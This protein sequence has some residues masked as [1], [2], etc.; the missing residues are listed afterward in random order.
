MNRR[1]LRAAAMLVLLAAATAASAQ[2]APFPTRPIK[3]VVPYPPGGPLDTAARAPAEQVKQGLGVVVVE[4]RPG[5]G[6]NIGVDQV[7][8]SVPDGYTLVIGAVATHAVNPWLFRKL[9]YDPV[10]DFVPITLIAHVPNVLVMT[11]ERAAQLQV[12][13]ARDLIDYLRRHPGQLNYASGGNGSAGHMAGELL[14][15]QGQVSAVHIPYA[16]AGP[17]Q[18]GLLAGQTDFMF[19]NLASATAQIKAGKLKAFAVTTPQ[20]APSLPDVPTMAESGVPGFDV[21]TWFGIFAPAGTPAPVVAR[22]NE[23]FTT[24]L[25]T[26]DMR[27]RLGRMGSEPAPMSSEQFAQLVRSELAKYEKVV[28]FS[29]ARVD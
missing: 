22:L 17:A 19:D 25:R 6:G 20:R 16:G 26:P 3:L 9:P 23:S 7:A 11:P 12:T 13:S 24:A 27:E 18:L 29:G 10:K 15:S 14:K 2:N 28:K 5:A 1:L 8:K 21:S 4:N